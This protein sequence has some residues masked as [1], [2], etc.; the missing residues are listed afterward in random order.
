MTSVRSTNGATFVNKSTK[1]VACWLSRKKKKTL[2]SLAQIF[3]ISRRRNV[4]KFGNKA[5]KGCTSAADG[6]NEIV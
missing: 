3:K 5:R 2:R 6:N 4:V 1:K